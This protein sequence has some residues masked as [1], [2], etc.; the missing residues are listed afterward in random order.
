MS[1]KTIAPIIVAAAFVTSLVMLSPAAEAKR[2]AD[3]GERIRVLDDKPTRI[4]DNGR[5]PKRAKEKIRQVRKR[6]RI[7]RRME[8]RAQRERRLRK[9][10][11]EAPRGEARRVRKRRVRKGRRGGARQGQARVH[12]KAKKQRRPK[13]RSPKASRRKRSVKRPK[14]RIK[15]RIKRIKRIKRRNKRIKRIHRRERL[16]RRERVRSAERRSPIRVAH[17]GRRHRHGRRRGRTVVVRH[18]PRRAPRVVHVHH[19]D[20]PRVATVERVEVV[21][22]DPALPGVDAYVG[23]NL[24]SF[25]PDGGLVLSSEPDTVGLNLHAGLRFDD[26]VALELGWTGTPTGSRNGMQAGTLDVKGFLSDGPFR[27][28]VLLGGG[29]FALQDASVTDDRTLAGPG[30]R[31]GAGFELGDDPLTL[32]VGGTWQAMA[33]A[34][35]ETGADEMQL[36]GA[37]LG[38][39]LALTF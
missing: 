13:A 10:R 11:G 29:V 1:N 32:Q 14:Q 36:S 23:A 4:R 37:S 35:L 31:V 6:R 3:S 19:R 16:K 17:V 5:K 18:R 21:E 9:R 34:D 39:G 27:P 12:E 22:P 15:Q 2:P 33:L 7:E 8:A 20:A 24:S 38:A 28:Y 26:R 25:L 30:V